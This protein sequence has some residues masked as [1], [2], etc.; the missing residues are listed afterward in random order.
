MCCSPESTE[1]Q[2]RPCGP[3]T[4]PLLATLCCLSHFF[5]I[6]CYLEQPFQAS[7][8]HSV[9]P[10]LAP[11]S[12]VHGMRGA[13]GWRLGLCVCR[14]WCWPLWEGCYRWGTHVAGFSFRHS[15]SWWWWWCLVAQLC[16]TLSQTHGLYKLP[17][18]SVHGIS[19]ARILEWVAISSSGDLS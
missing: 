5:Q 14:T 13:L 16:C 12:Q 19:Q 11:V 3:R 2:N 6:L 8:T 4:P 1:S 9:V 17:G 15:L 10:L 18:S 7:A